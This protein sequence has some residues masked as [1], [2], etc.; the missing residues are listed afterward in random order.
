MA[1]QLFPDSLDLISLNH[2]LTPLG[3]LFGVLVG[4]LRSPVS[5]GLYLRGEPA[6]YDL[7]DKL[8]DHALGFSVSTHIQVDLNV[9]IRVPVPGRSL[10]ASLDATS[11]LRWAS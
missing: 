8:A 1:I 10:L 9:Q 11:R 7:L 2:R 3:L 4:Y 6:A 5:V